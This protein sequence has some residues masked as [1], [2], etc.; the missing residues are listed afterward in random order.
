MARGRQVISGNFS[1]PST[2]RFSNL[3]ISNASGVEIENNVEVDNSLTLSEGVLL[4]G[5]NRMIINNG[6]DLALVAN[7]SAYIDGRLQRNLSQNTTKNA[8]FPM[9]KSGKKRQLS[10]HNF[11]GNGFYTV[12]YIDNDPTN[13]SMPSN[14]INEPLEIVSNIEYWSVEAPANASARVQL[15]WGQGSGLPEVEPAV[16]EANVLVA[17]WDGSS[18]WVSKGSQPAAAFGDG[19]G[20]VR[21]A[22]ATSFLNKSNARYFTIASQSEEDMPILP[23]EL[24]QLDA[25]AKNGHILISWATAS[26]TNNHF[27]TVE[28]SRDG[29]IFEL[30]S[31]ENSKA[32]YGNSSELLH[33][34]IKDLDPREGVTYYRLKQT[35][36]DGSFDYSR[37]VG[38]VYGKTSEVSFN[39]YPNPNNGNGFTITIS[40]LAEW[41]QGDLI[42]NDIYG[43]T[44]SSAKIEA[45]GSGNLIEAHGNG[46]KLNPGIY[47][48]SLFFPGEKYTLRMVVK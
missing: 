9:G 17:E 48:V 5:I 46:L 3:E 18:K 16:L 12:E 19:T 45:D 27:F 28:K 24:I 2:N 37:P 40:G 34:E 25:A 42:I 43:K 20:Y 10:L 14:E 15:H 31:H 7:A 38:V 13:E 32:P 44:I 41:Q 8:F 26:E 6:S 36:F 47:F 33:Y 23:I 11:T 22:Q 1:T 29:R 39:L 21:A 4:T 35:D 30:V